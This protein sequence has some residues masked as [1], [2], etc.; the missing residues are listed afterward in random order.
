MLFGLRSLVAADLDTEAFASDCSITEILD[1]P[2]ELLAT[3]AFPLDPLPLPLL[4]VEEGDSSL[5]TK[6]LA[7]TDC[8]PPL[9]SWADI[10]PRRPLPLGLGDT[11]CGS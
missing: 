4:T 10:F 3:E 8:L 9:G 5:A 7:P 6:E 11:S 1:F 2:T